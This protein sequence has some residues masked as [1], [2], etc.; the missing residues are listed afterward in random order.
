MIGFA[1]VSLMML[2]FSGPV[3]AKLS[4]ADGARQN[5]AFHIEW[6]AAS[7]PDFTVDVNENGTGRYWEGARPVG[8][9]NPEKRVVALTFTAPTIA[10]IFAAKPAIQSKACES[11]VKNI[12]NSGKKTLSYFDNDQVTE[13]V[14]NYSDDAKV[15]DST[16]IFLAIAQTVQLGDKLKH[17]HRFDHLGL[18]AD[19]DA[20]TV[21]VKGGYALELQN[22]API[23]QSIVSDD[24]MM[25]PARRKATA[26]LQTSGIQTA[27]S[28]Q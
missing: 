27:R 25:A 9:D 15:N 19:L 8:E 3:A 7:V 20:L 5:V 28:A 16:S 24:E 17:D 2:H 10:K 14:F 11:H 12:A 6:P 23:L 13:C 21:A 4:G 1:L 18:D 22:I 26:L